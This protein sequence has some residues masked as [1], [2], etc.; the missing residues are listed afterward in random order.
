M[1]YG[2]SYFSEEVPDV[3][4]KS[5]FQKYDTDGSGSLQ[6]SELMILLKQDLGMD[7]KQ[8]EAVMMMMDEDGSGDV[9][10]QEFLQFLRTKKDVLKTVDN[11]SKYGQLR[12][13][14]DCFKKFDEDGSGT[15]EPDELKQ[16]LQAIEYK[17][18]FE[19]AQ[20]KLDKDGDGKISF[21]EFFSFYSSELNVPK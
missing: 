17:G 7:A 21:P 12:K 3:V 19:S 16:L 13:A 14:V 2:G 18:S 9:S 8:A 1:S 11:T 6:K 5:I 20:E 4:V 10:L 15:I